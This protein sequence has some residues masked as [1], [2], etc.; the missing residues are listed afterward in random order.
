VV[1]CIYPVGAENEDRL[2]RP[3]ISGIVV[4]ESNTLQ[5]LYKM[6]GGGRGKVCGGPG[7]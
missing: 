2:Q 7:V 4:K 5:V 1:T 6:N 3:R